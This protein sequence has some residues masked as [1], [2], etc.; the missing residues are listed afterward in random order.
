M[1]CWMVRCFP[2]NLLRDIA[3]GHSVAVGL[4]TSKLVTLDSCPSHFLSKIL[5]REVS[6]V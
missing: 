5:Y 3:L 6:L 2:F 4:E 1:S